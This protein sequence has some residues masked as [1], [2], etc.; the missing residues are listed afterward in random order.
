MPTKRLRNACVTLNNYTDAQILEIRALAEDM[1][2]Y[3]VYGLEEGKEKGTPHLQI[4]AEFHEQTTF[5]KV[6]KAFCKGHIEP[7]RGTPEQAAGYCKKG[8]DEPPEGQDYSYFYHHPSLTWVGDEFGKLKATGKRK[9]L[10]EARDVI[11]EGTKTVDELTLEQPQLF[12]QYGRTLQKLEDIVLRKKFRKW[13]TTCDWL[14]GPTGVGKSHYALNDYDPDDMYI[15]RDDSGWQDDYVGQSIIVIN[16]FRGEIKY[17]E[18]LHPEI[19]INLSLCSFNC[20][21]IVDTSRSILLVYP[22]PDLSLTANGKSSPS[23]T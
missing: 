17:N 15:W 16:D 1:C 5:G 13:M 23:T 12:H 11:L 2:S 22:I 7:R 21:F 18:L 19:L 3:L 6:H 20:S 10:E 14:W 4:Y 9:D 8:E